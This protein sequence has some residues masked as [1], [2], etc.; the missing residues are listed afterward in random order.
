MFIHY[1][2]NIF[3]N[4][5]NHMKNNQIF[6]LSITRLIYLALSDALLSNAPSLQHSGTGLSA[7][8]LSIIR[9]QGPDFQYYNIERHGSP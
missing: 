9:P 6:L 1:F 2:K 7:G 8:R 4:Y 5:H 3:L